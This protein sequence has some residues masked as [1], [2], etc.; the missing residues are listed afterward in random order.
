MRTR[1]PFFLALVFL[2]VAERG[3]AQGTAFTYQGQLQNNGNPAS[4][5]YDITFT[6][7]NV[8]S[9]G[10]P[11]T[12]PLTNVATPVVNGLFTAS[13]DFGPG[14]FNGSNLW[15]EIAVST[16]AANAFSTLAPRQ[17]VTPAP[18]AIT[19]ANLSGTISNAQLSSSSVTVTAGSGLSGG[20]SVPLGGSTTLNNSG[21]LSVTAAGPLSSSGGQNPQISLTGNIPP[22]RLPPGLLTNNQGNVTL[23]GIF[24]GSFVGNASSATNFSGLLA[25]DVTGPQSAT[26]VS[27]DI[28]RLDGNNVFTGSNTFS[29]ISATGSIN[30][31]SG[32]VI[33]NRTNDPPAPAVGQIWLRTDL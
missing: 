27:A 15:L 7:F 33:E 18:Y 13:V 31:L 8:N 20:G 29:G 14:I 6:L 16:N 21:V 25:G 23:S 17:Q 28:P 1:I 3:L 32:L 10:A 30:A 5:S 9:G 12:T 24:T 22:D 2:L 4:G 19:A 26:V 11:V